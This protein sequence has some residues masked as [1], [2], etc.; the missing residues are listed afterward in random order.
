MITLQIKFATFVWWL[1]KGLA[2]NYLLV[3]VEVEEV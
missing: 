2:R 1:M 3:R